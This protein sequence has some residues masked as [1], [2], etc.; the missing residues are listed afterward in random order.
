S[1]ADN[2]VRVQAARLRKKL[3]EYYNEEGAQDPVQIFIARGHYYPEYL[4]A[5][6]TVRPPIN[7]SAPQAEQAVTPNPGPAKLSV[8]LNWR[9][10]ALGLLISNL[11]VLTYIL[12]P[13]RLSAD[14][15][16][17]PPL[18]KALALVWQPFVSSS[19]PPI[20]VYSNALFLMSEQGDLYRYYTET[21]HS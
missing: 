9:W 16:E 19:Q 14:S 11:A 1:K 5:P 6:L 20:I 18:A 2:I 15:P 13:L 12:W 4:T 10:L 3:A 21:S 7:S 17:S 8:P